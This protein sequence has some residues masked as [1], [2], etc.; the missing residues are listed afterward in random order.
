MLNST[1]NIGLLSIIAVAMIFAGCSDNNN[2]TNPVDLT[3]DVIYDNLASMNVGANV[4]EITGN[5]DEQPGNPVISPSEDGMR[6]SVLM[7]GTHYVV[8]GGK[9]F[10]KSE[11]SGELCE[12]RFQDEPNINDGLNITVV[13]YFLKA[14]V[15]QVTD[16]KKI[17]R[18]DIK[19]DNNDEQPGN[20]VIS[21]SED[22][23]HKSVQMSGTHYVKKG[24]KRF[25]KSEISGDLCELR[26][27]DEPNINDGLNITVVGYFLKAGVLQ[28]TDYKKII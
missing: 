19:P 1:K 13:G 11:K 4:D 17:I 14:G 15:L 18:G 25:L 10:L 16:Y 2:V 23:M 27:Q 3:T 9:R 8:K 22:G 5:D 6:K 28:V 24:G 21:P 26:F 20:P 12:L 7:S